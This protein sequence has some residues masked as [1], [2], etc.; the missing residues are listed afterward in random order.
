[1]CANCDWQGAVQLADEALAELPDWKTELRAKIEDMK[2]W[3]LS[4]KHTTDRMVNALESISGGLSIRRA[5]R[6]ASQVPQAGAALGV[7]GVIV[8]HV[9]LAPPKNAPLPVLEETVSALVR[10][11]LVSGG[12]IRVMNANALNW[13]ALR[14]NLRDGAYAWL[15]QNFDACVVVENSVKML[16]RGAYDIAAAFQSVQKLVGVARKLSTGMFLVACSVVPTGLKDMKMRWARAVD[17]ELLS[18]RLSTLCPICREPQI[19][20]QSGITCANGHS[21]PEIAQRRVPGVP[22]LDLDEGGW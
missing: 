19:D 10:Q 2:E 21:G 12:A 15:A 13:Q 1:M 5:P 7:S 11:A 4:N 8:P 9:L 16:G 18:A 17:P 14:G 3:L 6:G 22:E 20:T